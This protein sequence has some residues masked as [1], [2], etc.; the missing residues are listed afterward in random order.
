[1][2][3]C[4]HVIYKY[5]SSEESLNVVRFNGSIR[6]LAQLKQNSSCRLVKLGAERMCH[7]KG[8]PA[9]LPQFAI[10][11][12]AF[13]RSALAQPWWDGEIRRWNFMAC[14]TQ[15]L[16]KLLLLAYINLP[17]FL[18]TNN[19]LDQKGLMKSSN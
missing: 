5:A 13:Q 8:S 18:E 4:S 12:G 19:N 3:T 15:G 14:V 6:Q 11:M 7:W 9:H 16:D 10:K 1:M 2:L 17:I